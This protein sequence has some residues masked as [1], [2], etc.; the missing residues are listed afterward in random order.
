MPPFEPI[1]PVP[2]ANPIDAAAAQVVHFFESWRSGAAE[3]AAPA[4]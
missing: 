2:V 3:I 4:P 1:D